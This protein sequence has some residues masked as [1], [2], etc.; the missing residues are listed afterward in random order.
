M[1]LIGPV[2]IGVMTGFIA[3]IT[4]LHKVVRRASSPE[5]RALLLGAAACFVSALMRVPAV[6]ALMTL[7]G[8][9]FSWL[10]YTVNGIVCVFF[11][12]SY[13]HYVVDVA[14]VARP[15][16]ARHLKVLVAAITAM[17]VLF[18]AAPHSL[19]FNLGPGGLYVTGGKTDSV[20]AS[21][22]W[23]AL[24]LYQV[25]PLQDLS[26]VTLL[27]ARKTASIRW[28]S[29][30][31]RI[32]STGVMISLVVDIHLF[33][34]HSLEIIPGVGQLPWSQAQ[35]GAWPSAIANVCTMIGLSATGVYSLVSTSN[36][37]GTL[38]ALLRRA[39]LR[40]QYLHAYHSLYPLWRKLWEIVLDGAHDPP[41]NR[42]T[43][44]LR[45]RAQRSLYRRTIELRDFQ[46]TLSLVTPS[47]TYQL[48]LTL[49]HRQGIDEPA[50]AAVVDAAG[51]SVGAH[52]YSLG[53]PRLD[54]VTP[55]ATRHD[56]DLAEEARSWLRVS[57][58]YFTSPVVAHVLA[59]AL[60]PGQHD[61][62]I[63]EKRGT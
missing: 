60:D 46:R 47:S 36:R 18:V 8:V 61:S 39:Q 15:H 9:N 52:L 37:L 33:A 1:S 7:G 2:L 45:L 50:L 53:A 44:L 11:M 5:L 34:Y 14:E 38:R 28:L 62:T 19:E 3:T 4:H 54:R 55:P 23:V 25:Y 43:D 30:A 32:Y 58:A 27:W 24:G 20:A 26:R 57:A 51:I 31:L 40:W 16:I 29:I 48:A 63:R 13:V 42:L 12:L 49:C 10:G 22:A 59:A 35:V 21:L 6:S 17:V 41:R 56:G